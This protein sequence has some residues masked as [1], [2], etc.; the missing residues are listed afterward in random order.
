MTCVPNVSL[1]SRPHPREERVWWRLADPSGFINVDYFLEIKFPSINQITENN[2]LWC[3]T[4]I[5]GWWH[6]I[7]WQLSVHTVRYEFLT[8]PEESAQCHQTL[9]SRVGSGHESNL[10]LDS[11]VTLIDAH[12]YEKYKHEDHP[13]HVQWT[14]QC[15]VANFQH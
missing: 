5:L 6:S 4:G 8:K 11:M 3:N 14:W 1:M 15:C 13:V 2:D 9:S 10:M 12:H 7:F